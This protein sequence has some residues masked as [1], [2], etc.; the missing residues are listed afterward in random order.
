ADLSTRLFVCCT[1]RV[2]HH[3]S[4]F[5]EVEKYTFSYCVNILYRATIFG[6]GCSRFPV[7]PCPEIAAFG[8]YLQA[9]INRVA[10][11]CIS[12]RTD[13]AVPRAAVSRGTTS[14]N[15]GIVKDT[16]GTLNSMSS[17]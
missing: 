12:F 14:A 11:C 15:P 7:T 2:T 10:D 9:F 16:I 3:A 4:R 6:Y 1:L 5:L 8:V 13:V 17:L